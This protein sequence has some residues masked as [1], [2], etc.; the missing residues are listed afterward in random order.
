M[1]CKLENTGKQLKTKLE[2][3]STYADMGSI[4]S[5]SSNNTHAVASVIGLSVDWHGELVVTTSEDGIEVR[6]RVHEGVFGW[7]EDVG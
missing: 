3:R 1:L 6:E 5:E 4:G 2:A 7:F